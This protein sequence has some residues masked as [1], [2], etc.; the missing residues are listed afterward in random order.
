M[1]ALGRTPERAKLLTQQ[2]EYRQKGLGGQP[3]RGV[4]NTPASYWHEL[5]D[6][7]STHRRSRRSWDGTADES[8]RTHRCDPA[9]VQCSSPRGHDPHRRDP[10]P[11]PVLGSQRVDLRFRAAA[12]HTSLEPG[13]AR[14]SSAFLVAASEVGGCTTSRPPVSRLLRAS[15]GLRA[16]RQRTRQEVGMPWREI[17]FVCGSSGSPTGWG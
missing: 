17:V 15:T 9:E 2:S 8:P 14:S 10:R 6:A 7:P 1:L 4:S 5:R 12:E 3:T 11:R 16:P 13:G